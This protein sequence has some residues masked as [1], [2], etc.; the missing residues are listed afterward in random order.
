MRD[1][2]AFA[3][4]STIG[5]LGMLVITLAMG[6][7]LAFPR[8]LLMALVGCLVLFSQSSTYG[9]EDVTTTNVFYV[10]GSRTFFFAFIE[11]ALF[12]GWVSTLMRNGWAGDRSA[13]API[14]KYF[15]LFGIFLLAHFLV[16]LG[17]PKHVSLLDLSQSGVTNLL[18]QGMLV[19]MLASHV[20]TERDLRDLAWVLLA[21]LAM[22]QGF[23][24]V[25]YLFLG[26]DSQNAYATIEHIKV[27]ITFWDIND[28]LWASFALG[29]CAWRALAGTDKPMQQRWLWALG[30]LVVIATTM[31]SARRTA[32]GGM[33]LA[34][35]AIAWMVPRGRRWPLAMV[36]ALAVPLILV[37]L[38]GR[39]AD[40]G[41]GWMERI[42]ID[43]KSDQM[44]DTRRSRFH[45]LTT[46]W[47][48]LKEQPIL[49]VGPAGAFKVNDHVGLEFHGGNY[50]Y[51]HSGF[52]HVF[53]KLGLLG[54][55]SYIALFGSWARSCR[56]AAR[57]MSEP[58]RSLYVGAIAGF[59]A[60]IPTLLVGTPIIEIRTMLVLGVFMAIPLMLRRQSAAIAVTD[61]VAPPR[62]RGV[63]ARA[64]SPSRLG[65]G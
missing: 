55:L 9:V 48:T 16:G 42:L 60:A 43:V 47:Q 6:A 17:D 59:F 18:W 53:L 23:G 1:L 44:T 5:L 25:R 26:G 12:A 20:R 54:L 4:P 35:V 50:T 46:A 11:M 22:R 63:A 45:E 52:G 56:A 2:L 62:R 15:I 19:Y 10:K 7:M 34:M 38:G 58:S 37:A 65:L 13:R 57:V 29:F 30:A 49:G 24:V 3:V 27:K 8:W 40:T 14:F 36:A 32:Q 64:F 28:S 21:C 39:S 41:R 51:V 31:L 61:P 33:L